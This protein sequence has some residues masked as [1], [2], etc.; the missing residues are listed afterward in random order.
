M[1]VSDLVAAR[2]EREAESVNVEG[3]M[4][5]YSKG[6]GMVSDGGPVSER[7]ITTDEI[8]LLL[9]RREEIGHG[10][11]WQ[12]GFDAAMQQIEG[13]VAKE[14]GRWVDVALE[15][16][17][18]ELEPV[19]QAID[20]T[21]AAASKSRSRLTSRSLADRKASADAAKEAA[22]AAAAAVSDLQSRLAG[23]RESV[24]R[25]GIRA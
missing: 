14:G 3:P 7:S 25:D 6:N 4:V 15:V 2:W 22:R 9:S 24:V 1:D 18:R 12:A 19:A 11:G 16:V 23:L 8:S 13:R 10:R 20:V 5:G 21:Q 17:L